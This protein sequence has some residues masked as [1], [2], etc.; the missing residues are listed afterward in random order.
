M[1]GQRTTRSQARPAGSVAD[2]FSQ[3]QDQGGDLGD[4]ADPQ[5]PDLEYTPKGIKGHFDQ[6]PGILQ[7]LDAAS[8]ERLLQPRQPGSDGSYKPKAG[9]PQHIYDALNLQG[10][11]QWQL[12]VTPCR[13]PAYA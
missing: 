10:G 8:R 12:H 6:W 1:P 5:L 13:A 7:P 2:L 4:S 9:L 11:R 3:Q